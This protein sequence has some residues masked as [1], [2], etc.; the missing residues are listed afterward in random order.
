MAWKID[1]GN[2]RPPRWADSITG[3]PQRRSR[4]S[5][6]FAAQD[7]GRT[8]GTKRKSADHG[9]YPEKDPGID[10]ALSFDIQSRAF[11]IQSR[12]FEVRI[13]SA[14]ATV[15]CVPIRLAPGRQ[16][17]GLDIHLSG[18][19]AACAKLANLLIV[20]FQIDFVVIRHAVPVDTNRTKLC[21][22]L[23]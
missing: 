18:G 6:G 20:G 12:E 3:K 1:H 19:H 13:S 9:R 10:A 14:A 21:V 5:E 8:G 4:P 23:P 17:T 7:A 2:N 22:V 11:D 15:D 16:F